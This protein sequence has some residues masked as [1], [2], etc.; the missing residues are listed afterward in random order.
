MSTSHYPVA[1]NLPTNVSLGVLDAFDE[2]PA[3][4]I[5]KF[6]LI[7]VRAFAVVIKGGNL[8]PLLENLVRMLSVL[9]FQLSLPL[10]LRTTSV[11]PGG[12]LQWDEFDVTSY[13]AHSPATN[14]SKHSSDHIIGVWRSFTEKLGLKFE[15]VS[16]HHVRSPWC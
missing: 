5:A 10:W 6:D 1:A 9:S 15:L 7:H 2:V 4:Y 8:N 16:L 12:Y 14:I 13:A 11:E 3:D